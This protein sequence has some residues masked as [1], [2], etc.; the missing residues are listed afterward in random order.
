ME[1]K[2]RTVFTVMPISERSDGIWT[3]ILEACKDTGYDCVRADTLRSP[4]FIVNQIWDSIAAADIVVGEMSERNPN[5]FYEVGYAHALGKPTVLLAS[6][7][8]DLQAFDTA[9]FRHH[10]HG[11]DASKA[12]EALHDALKKL[13]VLLTKE[14]WP[15]NSEVVYQWPTQGDGPPELKWE[16]QDPSRRLQM[17]WQG[18]QR[19][20]ETFGAGHILAI[21]D[22]KE[23]WN[24]KPG[25]SIMRIAHRK[26]D[27]VVGD[28]VYI[29]MEGRSTNA[30][31][32]D[33]IADCGRVQTREGERF[34]HAWRH[35]HIAVQPTV[36]WRQWIRCV[37]V[38]PTFPYDL[39]R[40]VTVYL[41]TR[42]ESGTILLKGIRLLRAHRT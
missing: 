21:S 27:F 4:G 9:G 36:T 14:L 17:D 16:S 5:V 20:I 42:I 26:V 15:P 29:F 22:T 33:L 39:K 24:H 28:L 25:Q 7:E 31:S 40:G 1:N 6:S 23:L 32:I 34:A 12:R 8:R 18:G 19:V 37:T 41:L 35:E 2:A 30:G 13:D 38:E 10:L 3:A 11:G